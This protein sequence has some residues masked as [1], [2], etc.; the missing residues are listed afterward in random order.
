MKKMTAI[1]ALFVNLLPITA[2]AREQASLNSV[3]EQAAIEDQQNALGICHTGGGGCPVNC[4]PGTF[5]LNGTMA[6]EHGSCLVLKSEIAETVAKQMKKDGL[7]LDDI[8][9]GWGFLQ[10]YRA[11]EKEAGQPKSSALKR[12]GSWIKEPVDTRTP[13][14][15]KAEARA[16]YADA[17]NKKMK[18]EGD[19]DPEYA[20]VFAVWAEDGKIKVHTFPT[21]TNSKNNNK[22]PQI[23]RACAWEKQNPNARLV[24]IT[25][26]GEEACYGQTPCDSMNEA[27]GQ[28]IR[29]VSC[30]TITNTEEVGAGTSTN[31]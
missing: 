15:K 16:K 24:G 7:T 28:R 10:R 29:N 3:R 22:G 31:E 2:I 26:D 20:T 8:G 17:W 5:G 30:N 12:L 19:S 1:T 23:K 4:Q 18:E 11:A 9:G 25:N 13:E 27:V 14:Q 21:L 6:D